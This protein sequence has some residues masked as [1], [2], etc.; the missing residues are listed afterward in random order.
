MDRR[1]AIAW[2]LASL[3]ALAG[4]ALLLGSFYDRSWWPPDEGDYAHVAERLL[5][6][7]VLHRDVQDIHAGYVDFVN[8]A[9]LAVGGHRLVSLRYPLV[10]AAALQALGA[11]LLF[12]R[13][14]P[15]PAA[16]AA[17]ATNALGVVQFLD[18]TANWYC[19]ALFIATA[20]W[21]TLGARGESKRGP[22]KGAEPSPAAGGDSAG[23][24]QRLPSAPGSAPRPCRPSDYGGAGPSAASPLLDDGP[25]RLR[26]DSW[27]LAPRRSQP[28]HPDFH[29]G[30]LAPAPSR[31]R[32]P[33]TGLLVGTVVMFRQLT[34]VLLA[35]GVVT[36]L[37]LEGPAGEPVAGGR[38]RLARAL[39]G[40]MAVGLLGYLAT[41]TDFAAFALFGLWPLG[42]LVLAWRRTRLSD[43]EAWR[44]LW[45]LAAGAL[46]AA[47]PLV[48]YQLAHGA[49]KPWF[50]DAVD[51]ATALS[52]ASFIRYADYFSDLVVAGFGGAASLASPAAVANG[53]FWALLPLAAAV[54]GAWVLRLLGRRA[55]RRLAPLPLLA[56]F[57]ALVSVHY[58][59]PIYLFYSVG[60][61]LL[62]L[63][64][65][66]AEAGEVPARITAGALALL[67]GC[68]VYY[69]AGQS[70]N[71]SRE[72]M[73][74]GERIELVASDALPR[75]GLRIDRRDLADYGRLLAIIERETAP[76]EAIFA[77]P[78]DAELY[79]LSGRS[80]PFRFAHFTHAV[81]D[82]AAAREVVSA[83][84]RD[85]PTLLFYAPDDKYTTPLARWVMESV[86]D[87]YRFLERVGRIEVYRRVTA[88]PASAN[89]DGAA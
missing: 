74:R 30:L 10:L 15:W 88:P 65:L 89:G 24:G 76:G 39:L 54:E 85:P 11:F 47:L 52:Q 60:A 29:H 44:R 83:L 41:A 69:H 13:A 82:F 66:A 64:W 70:L 78:A 80:N 28:D 77:L 25:H 49:V 21:L 27:H 33:V 55:G 32:W 12:R 59:I 73:L 57:F 8:A 46:V 14:G 71:R 63:L 42:I 81:R 45:G 86:A 36:V 40:V 48:L 22:E 7:E 79:F 4:N 34:G 2:I 84:R 51:A 62:A 67:A 61:S 56:P 1:R 87:S 31:W 38:P 16:L 3:A 53:L 37:V 35:I 17:L 43:R 20:L 18:P 75:C 26:R 72:G 9:A 58:Q 23:G 6:G 5:A 50:D 19:L 68:G